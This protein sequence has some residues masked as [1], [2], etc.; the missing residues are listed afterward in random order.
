M[1]EGITTNGEVLPQKLVQVVNLAKNIGL[2]VIY[3]EDLIDPRCA[4]IIAEE[5]PG[6]KVV[7]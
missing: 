2:R 7:R 6:A 4:Q 3:S 5:I 1:H